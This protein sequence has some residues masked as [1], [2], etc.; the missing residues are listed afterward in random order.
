MCKNHAVSMTTSCA[1]IA[2][3]TAIYDCGHMSKAKQVKAFVVLYWQHSCR[4]GLTT[5]RNCRSPHCRISRCARTAYL[6]RSV[7]YR[8]LCQVAQRSCRQLKLLD[9]VSTVRATRC[10]GMPQQAGLAQAYDSDA[11]IEPRTDDE[12]DHQ[13]PSPTK[14]QKRVGAHCETVQ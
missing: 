8:H 1:A 10:G 11:S 2:R 7:D 4:G 12:A 6:H 5:F 3:P 14:E 9:C 13:E